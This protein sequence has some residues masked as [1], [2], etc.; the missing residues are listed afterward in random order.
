LVKRPTGLNAFEFCVVA[1]LR[2]AQL[3]RGCVPRV[4]P[5]EKVAMTAQQE[6]AERRV[7]PGVQ[8]ETEPDLEPVD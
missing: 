2:A 5:S 4:R 6:V 3:Q 1:G 7:V 8:V